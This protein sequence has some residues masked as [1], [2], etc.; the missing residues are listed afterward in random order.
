MQLLQCFPYTL[1]AFFRF[2]CELP[3]YQ[4]FAAGPSKHPYTHRYTPSHSHQANS[5]A[6][7]W[8]FRRLLRDSSTIRI[9]RE[10]RLWVPGFEIHFDA[11]INELSLLMPPRPLP[12]FHRPLGPTF[13]PLP[14]LSV[15]VNQSIINCPQ[16][17]E[18]GLRIRSVSHEWELLPQADGPNP[19]A[20]SCD[21]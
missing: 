19:S 18:N 12:T 9:K 21:Y 2:F 15:A 10:G 3:A 14:P 11:A 5:H 8:A 4:T 1:W 13:A 6:H 17:V 7:M 16:K 20:L